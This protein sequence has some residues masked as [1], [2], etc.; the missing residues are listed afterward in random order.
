MVARGLT[1]PVGGDVASEEEGGDGAQR[2]ER[3]GG[4]E[5]VECG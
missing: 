5:H 2:C 1:M 4:E 3:G